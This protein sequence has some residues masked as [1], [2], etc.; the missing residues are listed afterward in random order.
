M[1]KKLMNIIIISLFLSTSCKTVLKEDNP[2]YF[3][4]EGLVPNEEVAIKIAEAIWLPLYGDEIYSQKPYSV[5]LK[6]EIWYINGTLQDG[7]I[8]GV[9]YI[10]I[11]KTNGKILN[12]YH[13]K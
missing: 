2:S 11:Q 4:K 3:P 7:Y 10:E 8:G 13:T 12:V 6:N 5:I 1:Y 9:A